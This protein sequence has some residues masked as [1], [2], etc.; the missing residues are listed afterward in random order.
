MINFILIISNDL[1]RFLEIQYRIKQNKAQKNAKTNKRVVPTDQDAKDDGDLDG[2]HVDIN[3]NFTMLTSFGS[4]P[5]LYL[6]ERYVFE[7]VFHSLT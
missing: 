1:E 6:I 4:F 7:T 2:I 3:K 5:V